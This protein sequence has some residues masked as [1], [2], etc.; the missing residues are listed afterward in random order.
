M[1]TIETVR[2]PL[3]EIVQRAHEAIARNAEE[4]E[5]LE[6]LVQVTQAFAETVRLNAANP[7]PEDD[8]LG[9]SHKFALTLAPAER[10]AFFEGFHVRLRQLR[11]RGFLR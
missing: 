3:D 10:V 11:D 2:N 4:C 1:E 8:F 5:G 6:R 9:V 7:I